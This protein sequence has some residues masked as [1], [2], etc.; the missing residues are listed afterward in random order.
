[1]WIHHDGSSERRITRG[2]LPSILSRDLGLGY[3][4]WEFISMGEETPSCTEGGR[5]R[6]ERCLHLDSVEWQAC[7][8]AC[9]S[10]HEGA[11]EPYPHI[12]VRPWDPWVEPIRFRPIPQ[13]RDILGQPKKN[14]QST[15]HSTSPSLSMEES[16]E[17]SKSLHHCRR[18]RI[19]LSHH[20]KLPLRSRAKGNL[21]PGQVQA[22][23][24]RERRARTD[25]GR[26]VS[27]AEG[28]AP[29]SVR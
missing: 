12:D 19:R 7:V 27:C 18:A 10:T 23:V 2:T 22:S 29:V 5:L 24:Q 20:A 26:C 21:R 15:D 4:S 25:V 17:F 9:I 14:P 1:M 13:S 28:P 16:M 6:S 11:G 8:D 3:P